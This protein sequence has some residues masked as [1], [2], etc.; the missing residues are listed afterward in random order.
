MSCDQTCN[1][2]VTEPPS[3]L[4]NVDETRRGEWLQTFTGRCFW[5]LDPR[6]S[7]V[8]IE[9]IA[10][11]LSMRCRYGGHSLKFYSV[12]EHSVLVSRFVPAADALWALL[13]DAAE[14]YSADVPRPLK[15][16]MPDFQV[17]EKRIM[18]AVSAR[19]GLPMDEPAAVK[20]V[21][22]AITTDERAAFM[23]R[24]GRDWGDLPAPIGAIIRCLPP[25]EAEREFL[26]RFHD[27]LGHWNV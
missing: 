17:M 23:A 26:A 11:S 1:Q 4:P 27:I 13:H 16:W 5:P 21:D 6:P 9:D 15:R 20:R 12:A 24:C 3:Y 10:H 22:L 19:F 8:C 18:L 25:A 14:A 7:E 2:P